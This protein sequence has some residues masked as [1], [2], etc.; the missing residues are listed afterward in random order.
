MSSMIFD[1]DLFFIIVILV[2]SLFYQDLTLLLFVAFVSWFNDV[3]RFIVLNFF[4][5]SDLLLLTRVD[6]A[7]WYQMLIFDH[8]KFNFLKTLNSLLF[9]LIIYLFKYR[10]LLNQDR[11]LH[12]LQELYCLVR[13]LAVYLKLL[14]Q[15]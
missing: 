8:L 10:L 9:I 6:L 4:G 12:R 2:H 5:M 7:F 3:N 1:A 11:F 13:L 15:V 14:N